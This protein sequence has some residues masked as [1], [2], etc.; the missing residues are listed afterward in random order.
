MRNS[1]LLLMLLSIFIAMAFISTTTTTIKKNPELSLDPNLQCGAPCSLDAGIGV[2]T[3]DHECVEIDKFVDEKRCCIDKDCAPQGVCTN[4]KCRVPITS[5][6]DI[7]HDGVVDENDINSCNSA[8][9]PDGCDADGDG[10]VDV[11]DTQ[12]LAFLIGS[13]STNFPECPPVTT[14]NAQTCGAFGGICCNNVCINWL[15]DENNCGGC[16]VQCVAGTSCVSGSCQSNCNEQVC[17]SFGAICCPGFDGCV[18]WWDDENNCGGCR[19][20]CDPGE[21]CVLNT[22]GVLASGAQCKVTA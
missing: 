14:C 15:E 4:G 21:E 13:P 2:A 11:L 20:Q 18:Q 1:I 12:R 5:C 6:P 8:N 17:N 22:P 9:P 7:N 16:D 3:L 19:I 10:D